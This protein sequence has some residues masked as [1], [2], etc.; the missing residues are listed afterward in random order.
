MIGTTITNK[1]GNPV[2]GNGNRLAESQYQPPEQVKK[3]FAQVQQNYL[4]AYI[5]QHRPFDEF[6]GVSLLQR[7][8]LDQQTF[9]AYVGA[10]YVPQHKRWRFRGRKNTSRNKI[11]GI[12]AHMIAGMLYPYVTAKN[13]EN[14]EDKM[15]ARVMRILVEEHLK[16]ADYEYKFL[17]MVLTA[18]VNP[19]T[20]VEVEWVEALQ[21]IKQK[22]ADGSY[23]VVE[24]VDELLS[25][26]NLNTVPIDQIMLADFYT[27]DI[28]R[29]PFLIRVRRIPYD[30]AR[31]IYAG[32]FYDDGKDRFDY[33]MA[34][35]TRIFLAGQENQT[36]YDIEWTEADRNYVQEITAYYKSEDL[37]VTFVGGVFMGNYNDIYNSNPFQH[38]RFTLINNKDWMSV[39][40]YP[41]AKSYFEPL[42]PTGRFAYGKSAAFKEYWDDQALNL[43]HRLALDG[44]YLDV[45][46]PLFISGLANADSVVIAPGATTAM[47]KD[48]SIN[49][50]QL[51]PNIPAVY[52]AINQQSADLSE[53]TQDKIMTGQV[54]KGVTAYATSKAEAN[55]RIFLGQ[56]GVMIG[57]LIRQ[58]GELTMDCVVNY[59]TIGQLDMTVPNSLSMKYKTFL[60]KGK[61][62]GKTVTNKV[63]FTDKYMGK[64]LSKSKVN[65]IEWDLYDQAGGYASD[66]RIY[67][68]NPYQFARYTYTMSVD[69]DEITR[70][71]MGLDRNAKIL[72]FNMMSD[73]RVAP[74]TDQ[75]AVV[76]D[77][78]IEEFGGSDPDKYKN[79]NDTTS[80]DMLN[81]VLG[82]TQ[83]DNAP[84]VKSNPVIQPPVPV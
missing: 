38:R 70:K 78:V 26:L 64:K 16:K 1:D 56:F 5:L 62:K 63:V 44:T 77:F 10:E 48:A 18:L 4:T 40:I 75:Q 53:S 46:K 54:E 15:A 65:Q 42:D 83:E 50:Y 74:F 43:M 32:K 39:P 79:K 82:K 19:A 69:A 52:N 23:K 68:V 57:Y 21:R 67:L 11:I 71:S 59:S 45:I 35:Y 20:I 29:Q 58:V 24:A 37:Q 22:M 17:N 51:S 2:D 7:T 6:D 34:G 55:A 84:I 36:L 73:P 81:S 60:S 31:Q 14:E 49:P 8:R 9:A 66:Q 12:L 33:V 41:F 13:S 28:Q 72:A 3:L 61:D 47:P 76:D 80:P 30:Q 25:G 27:G